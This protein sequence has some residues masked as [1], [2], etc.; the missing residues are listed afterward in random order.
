MGS[1]MAPDDCGLPEAVT[2]F[3]LMLQV[4]THGISYGNYSQRR[5]TADWKLNYF[6]NTGVQIGKLRAE[7]TTGQITGL[8]RKQTP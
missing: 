4:M 6:T 2:A 5:H 1:T 8:L 7:E 3:G